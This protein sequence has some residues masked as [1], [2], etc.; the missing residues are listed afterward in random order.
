MDV[1]D[2]VL[3]ERSRAGGS[4]A[5]G[6]LIDRYQGVALRVAYAIAPGQAEDVVQE[7]FV[8][9]YR[10]LPRFRDDAPFRP[11]LLRIVANEARN[12]VRRAG[13]QERLAIRAG[14]RRPTGEWRTPEESAVD[15]E[16]RRTLALAVSSLSPADREVIALRWFAGLSETEMA[17]ALDCRPGTVKS[18]L[19][20]AL[21]R[22]RAVMPAE[23]VR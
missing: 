13:R 21:E 2:E 23:A 3:L 16:T 14:S 10:A 4:A 9:A 6:Q 11:W 17:T 5:F 12:H 7:A 19:S 20:R 22:L 1:P 15:E 18:R 8:K